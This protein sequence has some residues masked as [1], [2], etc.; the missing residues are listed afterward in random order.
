MC[1]L[2]C[3]DVQTWRAHVLLTYPKGLDLKLICRDFLFFKLVVLILD[4]FVEGKDRLV[5]GSF[6][7]NFG[8]P[9]CFFNTGLKTE[10]PF[11]TILSVF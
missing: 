10:E 2:G 6:P 9:G 8:V 11:I 3:S 5:F 7:S 4:L 1:G